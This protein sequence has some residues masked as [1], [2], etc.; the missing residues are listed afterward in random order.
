MNKIEERFLQRAIDLAAAGRA[1]GEEPF[2]SLLV[3]AQGTVLAE[4]YNTVKADHDISAHPE[5][6]LAKW[7]SVNLAPQTAASVTMYTSCQPCAMCSGAIDRSG[8]GRVVYALSNQQFAQ[9]FPTRCSPPSPKMDPHSS[10]RHAFPWRASTQR[11]IS[12]HNLTRPTH[13]SPTHMATK[14]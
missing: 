11:T 5:F 12:E 14:D 2:G 10:S 8:L 4:D 9:L 3:D 6:K 7:A 1:A 13:R